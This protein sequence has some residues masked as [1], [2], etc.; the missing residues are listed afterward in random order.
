M[1]EFGQFGG[2]ID[3]NNRPVV[4]N[5][6]G[7]VSTVR[8]ISIG[9]DDGEVL[10]PTVSDDGKLMSDDEAID[11]YRKTGKRLGVFNTP[12][13]ATAYAE[14]LHASQEAR[15]APRR[16]V[17]EF[18]KSPDFLAKSAAEKASARGDLLKGVLKENKELAKLWVSTD[19]NGR[20]KIADQWRKELGKRYPDSFKTEG[21]VYEDNGGL[22]TPVPVQLPVL[23]SGTE[24]IIDKLSPVPEVREGKTYIKRN[25][26][27]ETFLNSIENPEHRRQVG[28]LMRMR[29]GDMAPQSAPITDDIVQK[30]PK[31]RRVGGIYDYPVLIPNAIRT[32]GMLTGGVVGAAASAPTGPGA[33]AGTAAGGAIG[34]A[35]VEPVAQYLEKNVFNERQDYSVSDAA[36]NT[37]IG[38]IP[39]APLRGAAPLVRMG[40]R[41]LEGGAISG[42]IYSVQTALN[43]DS[44]F[45]WKELGKHTGMGFVLGGAIGA[46]EA[47]FL[48]SKLGIPA[49]KL[50]G[51]K[52]LELADEVAVAKRMTRE[53][54]L[55]FIKDSIPLNEQ[56]AK[57]RPQ[58]PKQI[59]MEQPALPGPAVEAAVPPPTSRMSSKG[60]NIDPKLLQFGAAAGARGAVGGA[61]GF[62][63]GDTP[64][65]R[66]GLSLAYGLAGAAL[67][68]AGIRKL[69]RAAVTSNPLGR[70]I[71]PEVV[72]G[73]QI[74]DQVNMGSAAKAALLYKASKV[75][76]RM[77]VG[78]NS[79][80]KS[81]AAT[82]GDIA[83][84]L[85]GNLSAAYL[86]AE[87]RGAAVEMRVMVDSL[88]DRLVQ[89]GMVEGE[90]RNTIVS[91]MGSYLR[92]SFKVFSEPNW[93]PEQAVYDRFVREAVVDGMTPE[94]ANNLANRLLDRE[95][96]ENVVMRGGSAVGKNLSSFM[97]RKNLDEATRALLGEITDPLQAFG[98]TTSRL[99]NLVEND[100]TQKR[101]ADIGRQIG[102]FSQHSNPQ[103]GF[104]VEMAKAGNKGFDNFAGLW[105][106]PEFRKAFERVSTSSDV[107]EIWRTLVT[108]NALSKASKTIL[109]PESHAPNGIGAVAGVIGNGHLNPRNF[110]RGLRRGTIA[111]GDELPFVRRIGEKYVADKRALER[112]VQEM[113]RLG[114]F[115]ES[116]VTGDIIRTANE[117]FIGKAKATT[118]ALL[119]PFSA[120]YAGTDNTAKMIAYYG[121]LNRY[122]R[123]FPNMAD[124]ELK[125]KAAGIVRATT[126]TYGEIPKWVKSASV[127]GAF[128]TFVNFTWEVFRNSHNIAR[129]ASE[130]IKRGMATGNKQLVRAGA[131]RIAAWTTLLA[132]GIGVSEVSRRKAGVSDSQEA[133]MRRQVVPEWDQ[134]AMLAWDDYD[135]KNVTYA[136][137]SYVF[138][139]A[140]AMQG[141]QSAL[142]GGDAGEAFNAFMGSFSEQFL[143][144]SILIKP[145]TEAIVGKTFSGR[146]VVRPQ[147]TTIESAYDRILHV[148]DKGYNPLVVPV[149]DKFLKAMR[150]EKGIHGEVYE[151]GD[152]VARMLGLRKTKL[153]IDVR[154]AQ[155]ASRLS[156]ALN[157]VTADYSATHRLNLKPEDKQARYDR[158][159]VGRQR[160]FENA[161]QFVADAKVLGSNEDKIIKYFRDGGMSSEFVLGVL[162][163]VY[164]P[165][166]K[167]KAITSTDVWESIANLPTEMRRAKIREMDVKTAKA[168]WQ[169]EREV[170]R[171]V[172]ERD[173]LIRNL[174]AEDGTRARYMRRVLDGLPDEK[175]RQ[176]QLN[177]WMKARVATPV[178]LQ[179]LAKPIRQ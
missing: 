12:E 167:D 3:L 82:K 83:K 45:S 94:Q 101:V 74:L 115:G 143:S 34:A 56:L 103:A 38:G 61:I 66:V 135:G 53:E 170:V 142:K 69:G 114:V 22:T 123:A 30:G 138:P 166:R 145:T 131:E 54:S 172:D 91:N 16:K 112:E 144:G 121:E 27:A 70:W 161:R 137:Q 152:R 113:I 48:G 160:I 99:I 17:S 156:G 32:A 4:K 11:A 58:Q 18:V 105:T 100:A 19:D 162:D 107:G 149:A 46:V 42:G 43:P 120:V 128:P 96:A 136:N 110:A 106:T 173:K 33:V 79:L 159:E 154:L 155:K 77:D 75:L 81:A 164:V 125:R 93:R 39:F 158:S 71:A 169:R 55:E 73:K 89:S 178:V 175:A 37:A 95:T 13:E 90:L 153:E 62:A 72:I 92:R 76:R 157:D 132:A 127:V 118:D 31:G 52:L 14:N 7:S 88:S 147:A 6:D 108:A 84:Y 111:V 5:K 117:S 130:D 129:I 47:K 163:G 85:K 10:I 24:A 86:P 15:Y 57:V 60:G 59:G 28:E 134:G 140:V 36:L 29:W 104:T 122:R 133:A 26:E 119:L 148:A 67:S 63:Q 20:Q 23:D 151:V 139:P 2:N 40:A 171:E 50:T 141:F 146:D 179:Q 68:P 1:A 65:D 174:G 80:G 25:P 109:N 97:K 35:A 165:G 116:V 41:S 176:R 177:D 102:V 21:Y 8:S 87:V 51:V 150:E 49:D 44:E 9:T 124:E 168:M 64:E 78:L 126:Q 98:E